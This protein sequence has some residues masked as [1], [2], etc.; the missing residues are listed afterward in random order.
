MKKIRVFVDENRMPQYG[1]RLFAFCQDCDTLLADLLLRGLIIADN[2]VMPNEPCVGEDTHFH[3]N[4]DKQR[5]FLTRHGFVNVAEVIQQGIISSIDPS[6]DDSADE[7][8]ATERKAELLRNH[9]W[10]GAEA[11]DTTLTFGTQAKYVDITQL[12]SSPR[13]TRLYRDLLRK[14]PSFQTFL[15]QF[16]QD[17]PVTGN[18]FMQEVTT[19]EQQAQFFP[20]FSAGSTT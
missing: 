3:T 2:S 12:E 11:H 13:M 16:L 14:H 1:D 19:V 4:E 9:G 7:T 18:P 20:S 17:N 5:T 6:T 15:N 10:V 8:A